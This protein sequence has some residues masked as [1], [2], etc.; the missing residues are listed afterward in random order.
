MKRFI[1]KY[2]LFIYL[3]FIKN[4]ENMTIYKKWARP[5]LNLLWFMHG[6]YF[7]IL[8]IL[9]FPIFIIGMIIDK[10]LLKIKNI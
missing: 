6:L 4:D 8:S 3:N 1:V 10:R 9:I 7:W 5:L 2:L